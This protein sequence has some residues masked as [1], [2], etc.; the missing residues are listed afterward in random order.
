[1]SYQLDLGILI[2]LVTGTIIR[3]LF[4]K[5]LQHPAD[6]TFSVYPHLNHENES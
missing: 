3:K 1:M 5:V 4:V 2:P 6:C